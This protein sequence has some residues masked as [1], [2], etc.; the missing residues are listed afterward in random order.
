MGKKEKKPVS[1]RIWTQNLIFVSQRCTRCT[2][3]GSHM[4]V[5]LISDIIVCHDYTNLVKKCPKR[6]S[7]ESS[8]RPEDSSVS[9]SSISPSNTE[10]RSIKLNCP[11]HKNSPIWL[12]FQKCPKR[13]SLES[14]PRPENSGAS[15]S[16][17][18]PS[19]T[20]IQSIECTL[21]GHFTMLEWIRTLH[22]CYPFIGL[23]LWSNVNVVLWKMN[24]LEVDRLFKGTLS[25]SK[26][27]HVLFAIILAILLG[28]Y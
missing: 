19:N 4:W 27:H 23:N 15:F 24:V 3:L 10:I 1:G 6:T 18:S 16:S 21:W 5:G 11:G 22:T 7:L 14:S 20:E 12:L 2:I 13:K 8:P 17:I 9:F 26:F 25:N 28:S